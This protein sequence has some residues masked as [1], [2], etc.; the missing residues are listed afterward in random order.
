MFDALFQVYGTSSLRMDIKLKTI[1]EYLM[2]VTVVYVKML[3]SRTPPRH[4]SGTHDQWTSKAYSFF[5]FYPFL[6]TAACPRFTVKGERKLRQ[7]GR[8]S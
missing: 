1:G 8:S 6:T 3:T 5:R 4:L 2:S 7:L